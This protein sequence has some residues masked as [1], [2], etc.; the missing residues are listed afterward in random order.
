MAKISANGAT[1]IARWRSRERGSILVLC[2][3]GRILFK[4]SLPRDGYKL[5]ARVKKSVGAPRML[6][7]A[8]KYAARYGEY[9]RQA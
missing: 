6:E 3:D 5:V 9:D 7:L 2:S 8:E 4:T 1:E